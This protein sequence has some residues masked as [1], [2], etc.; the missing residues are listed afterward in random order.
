MPGKALVIVS[1]KP[2][3]KSRYLETFPNDAAAIIVKTLKEIIAEN[4][5][6]TAA[7]RES[8]VQLVDLV[9][10]VTIPQKSCSSGFR[11]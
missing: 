3:Q 2:V 9:P 8:Q 6:Y 5:P 4:S 10:G 7:D 11:G 1:S